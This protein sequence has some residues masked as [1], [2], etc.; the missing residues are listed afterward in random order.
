MNFDFYV[1]GHL[2]FSM[3][4]LLDE[5]DRIHLLCVNDV[6]ESAVQEKLVAPT[7]ANAYMS[8][9][10]K[11]YKTCEEHTTISHTFNQLLSGLPSSLESNS[12]S[13]CVVMENSYRN[14]KIKR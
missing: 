11:F 2:I 1:A 8:R 4:R 5:W 12:F 14:K 9:M 3:I 13:P 10:H 7:A 6:S